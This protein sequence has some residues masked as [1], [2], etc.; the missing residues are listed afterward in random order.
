MTIKEFEQKYKIEP[1]AASKSAWSCEPFLV[2][3]DLSTGEY[4]RQDNNPQAYRHFKT[5]HEV[6]EWAEKKEEKVN[7]HKRLTE[8]IGTRDEKQAVPTMSDNKVGTNDCLRKLAE[9]EDIMER[10]AKCRRRVFALLKKQDL[11][12][13]K[14]NEGLIEIVKTYPDFF[15]SDTEKMNEES[16]S[17]V[18][19]SYL[20]CSGRKEMFFG[21]S[22]EEALEKFEKWISGK[23][24]TC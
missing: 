14:S 1:R 6:F 20:L 4:I 10:F 21:K 11:E 2:V 18:L 9:Y 15:S 16:V 13:S 19:Y 7:N 23:E 5:S 8:W 22:F 12:F 3:L 17:I 24:K